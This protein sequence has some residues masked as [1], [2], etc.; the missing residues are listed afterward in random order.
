M[1][2][3]AWFLDFADEHVKRH[4][5]PDWPEAE[6]PFF[7][8]WEEALARRG[9]PEEVAILASIRM[10]EKSP[11]YQ[12]EHL[13]DLL[14]TADAIIAEQRS[15]VVGSRE[16]A[17]AKSWSC[18]DCLG[19]GLAIRFQHQFDSGRRVQFFCLCPKGR[20][21]LQTHQSKSTDVLGR[22]PDLA[23]FPSL[24]IHRVPWSET[25]DHRC[26][27]HPDWWDAVNDC[28]RNSTVDYR[29]DILARHDGTITRRL[30][31]LPANEVCPHRASNL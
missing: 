1:S 5:R 16:E 3:L 15:A 21:L 7:A 22:I 10:A 28:P 29:A 26:R 25:P 23:N 2:K 27:Y 19:N 13:P 24:R 17:E 20:W 9:V 31:A 30:C 12:N 8:A 6:S 18:L 4:D 11:K 14:E